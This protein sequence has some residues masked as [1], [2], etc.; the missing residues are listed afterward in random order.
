MSDVTHGGSVFERYIMYTSYIAPLFFCLYATI[1]VLTGEPSS[2][3]FPF[4]TLPCEANILHKGNFPSIRLPVPFDDFCCMRDFQFGYSP[5]LNRQGFH[6]LRFNSHPLPPTSIVA[7]AIKKLIVERKILPNPY[8]YISH[9]QSS[10]YP[11]FSYGRSILI[12][13]EMLASFNR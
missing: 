7:E 11:P 1:L 12:G 9:L 6:P 2:S 4:I 3:D 5:H 13:G 8:R 10:L